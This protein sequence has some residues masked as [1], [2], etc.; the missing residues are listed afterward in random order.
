MPQAL[1][2]SCMLAA[3]AHTPRPGQSPHCLVP[4]Q[5]GRYLPFGVRW[6]VASTCLHHRPPACRRKC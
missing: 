5:Q 6:L 1:Q 4:L 3:A 2:H